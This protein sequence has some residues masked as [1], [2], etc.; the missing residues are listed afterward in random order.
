MERFLLKTLKYELRI[1]FNVF[2]VFV[3]KIIKV[4]FNKIIYKTI[5]D[6]KN[7]KKTNF[8]LKDSNVNNYQSMSNE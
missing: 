8:H 4:I 5:N 1:L 2:T 3:T 7:K 6:N